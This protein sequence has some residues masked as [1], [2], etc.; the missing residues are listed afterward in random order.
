MLLMFKVKNYMSFREETILDMRAT[1]YVQHPSH[2]ISVNE[3]LRLLKMTV[4]YGANASGKSNFISAMFFFERYIFSQFFQ[5][6]RMESDI[7]EENTVSL[8]LPLRLQP[9]ALADKGNDESEFEIIFLRGG[10]MFQYG[11]VCSP[12]KIQSEWFYIDDQKVF[13]REEQKLSFGK[14][15]KD[16]LKDYNKVPVERL[17]LSVLDFFLEEA[18]K[19]QLLG[20]FTAFF[21]NDFHVFTEIF[22][23]PS[24]KNFGA[25]VGLSNELI[26]NNLFRAKVEQYLRAIDIG[27][28]RL[29]VQTE[30]ILRED[31]GKKEERHIIRTVHDVYDEAGN[32]TG[33]KLLD[34]QQE[35]GGTLRF[36]SYIQRML[37]VIEQ[38]GV[39]IVDELSAKLHP[40]LTNLI[41]DL[42]CSSKNH[43]AQLIFTTH[44]ISLLTRRRRR[45]EIVFVEKN[46]RGES[47][48]Y[49]LSDLKVREDA[50]FGKDYLQGKYGAIPVFHTDELFGGE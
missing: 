3:R 41:V 1:S 20:D 29:D 31:T 9:F 30:T 42:F 21:Q 7:S 13:E 18:P 43:Q 17:Y 39:L 36:L 44:D 38:G 50:S 35:S 40:L 22:F 10:K 14:Q 4:L 2:V 15:Y 5:S 8:R 23:D 25:M 26:E 45:D 46:A 11:F 33:E 12:K 16:E 48:L 49:S 32:L 37:E 47:S 28:K 6:G 34:L 19:E 27:I 24:V